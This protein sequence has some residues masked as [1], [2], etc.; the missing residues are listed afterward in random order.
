[1]S[2]LSAINEKFECWTK[3]KLE[4]HTKEENSKLPVMSYDK[5]RTPGE[6]KM[7]ER[8][9]WIAEDDDTNIIF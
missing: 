1:L 7:V 3:Y 6:V 4:H 8:E 9:V 5:A 2:A